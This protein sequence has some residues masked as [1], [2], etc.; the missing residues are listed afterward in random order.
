MVETKHLTVM[1][2]DVKGFTVTTSIK[3]REDFEKFL[4][5]HEQL[6]EPIFKKYGGKIIKTIGDAFMVT[7]DSPTNAVLCGINIQEKLE[8]YNRKPEVDEK[9]EVRVAINSG[10]V[11]LRKDDIFGEAVNIAA[12]I[13]GIAEPNEV[14]F[15][16][17]VYLA[18]NKSEIPSAEVGYRKLKGIPE[19]IKVYKVLK[20]PKLAGKS[21]I[22]KVKLSEK[23]SLNFLTRIK[24]FWKRRKRW[25]IAVLIIIILIGIATDPKNIIKKEENI[26]KFIENADSAIEKGNYEEAGNLANKLE[27]ISPEKIPPRLALEGAKLYVFMRQPE[28][29]FKMIRIAKEN[30]PTN[31]ESKQIE[32]YVKSLLSDASPEQKEKLQQF[33]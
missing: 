11:H 9:V 21:Q 4:D 33:I 16:E 20:E 31:E 15:T 3:K 28:D 8:E 30:Y 17:S 27:K 13:E 7:F 2:T 32:N 18:M 23:Q 29:A 19:E 24:G 5:L 6:I 25:I 1:F 14:Y 22:K 12:R 26:D 10:E